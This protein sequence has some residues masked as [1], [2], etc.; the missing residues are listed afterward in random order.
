MAKTKGKSD[1][2]SKT[3]KK[4]TSDG[5]SFEKLCKIRDSQIQAHFKAANTTKKYGE[6]V[7]RGHAFLKTLVA[8]KR[9]AS[10]SQSNLDISELAKAFDDTPNKF[11]STALELFLV[12]KC[13]N[14]GCS[15]STAW[16]ILSGFKAHWDR[17]GD[18]YRGP[19]QC[20][21][22]TGRVT[23][24]PAMSAVVK[25]IVKT[26]EN[27]HGADGGS[28]NHAAAMTIEDMR[29]AM[30]WSNEQCPTDALEQLVTQIENGKAIDGAGVQVVGEHLL[31]RAYISSGFT[32]WTRNFELTKL[33]Q[34][35]IGWDCKGPAPYFIPHF[36][37]N[38]TNRKGWQRKGEHD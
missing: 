30:R 20:D 34:K 33:Q 21:E 17:Q 10:S 1:T 14:Q 12:E 18:K 3:K 16:G 7:Q 25:D 38:L 2:T 28:R 26:I 22:T 13:L 5:P 32:L 35:D 31:I 29:M 36:S 11:S 37:V 8:E 6:Y 4:Q 23:G 19:Y 9:A 27:K 24:N 15:D